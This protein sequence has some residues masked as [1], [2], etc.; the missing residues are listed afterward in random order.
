MNARALAAIVALGILLGIALEGGTLAWRALATAPR[1]AQMAATRSTSAGASRSTSAGSTRSPSA[2][3]SP[4]PRWRV[5]VYTASRPERTAAR[6]A[7][8]IA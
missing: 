8:D 7:P 3:A 4:Y 6:S 1:G 5:A 2:I